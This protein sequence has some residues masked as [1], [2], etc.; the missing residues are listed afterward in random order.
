MKIMFLYDFPLFGSGSATYLRELAL[1]LKSMG[2]EIAIVAPDKRKLDNIIHFEVKP[3]QLGVFVGHP[4]LKNAK[5]YKDMS[6]RELSEIYTAYIKDTTHAVEEFKPHVIHVFHLSFIA[7]VARLMKILYGVPFVVTVHGSDLHY[8]SQ[9]RRFIGLIN[10]ALRIAKFISCNSSFTREWF[11]KMFGKEYGSKTRTILG[12]VRP[13]LLP[14]GSENLDKRYDLKEKHLALFTGRLTTHKGVEYLVK[15]AKDIKGE[16]F[17]LGDGPEREY[18][19]QLVKNR[20]LKN[21]T[22]LGYISQ[23]ELGEFYRRADVYVAPSVWDEPLGLV[24]LEAMAANT[25]VLVT[26]KGGITSIV[27]DGHNGFFVRPRNSSEI[28]AKVN[29]LFAD[30]KLRKKM[31]ENAERTIIQKKFMWDKISHRFEYIYKRAARKTEPVTIQG[32]FST[33]I[34]KLT[35]HTNH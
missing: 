24:I 19:T 18:L 31:G 35:N 30:E 8:L 13:E 6:G 21:V 14:K 12:G 33:L 16:V 11:I 3:P 22:L 25:P 26:K 34:E 7:P 28:A 32:W 4:E 9:D 5:K 10:D 27:K 1:E 29:I 23:K 15:A 2:H 20:G 17:I